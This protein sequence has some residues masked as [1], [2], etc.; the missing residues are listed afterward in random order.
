M[1]SLEQTVQDTLSPSAD[2]RKNAENLLTTASKQP[3]HLVQ[4][5]QLVDNSQQQLPIRQAAAIRFKNIVKVAWDETKDLADRQEITI[6]PTDRQTIKTNLVSLMCTVPPQIRNQVSAAISLIAEVDYPEKWENLLPDLVRQFDSADMNVVNGVLM[7]ADSIFKSFLD[8]QRSDQLYS[9]ILYTLNVIQEPL[10]K[11]FVKMGTE[12]DA[13]PTDAAKLTPRFEALRLI[14][15]IYYSLVYQDLPEYFENNM[16]AWMDGFAKFLQYKN[17][18][19]VD[20]DE[21]D[22][23]GPIDKLQ[24]EIVRI[25]KLFVERDEEPFAEFLQ[26]FTTLVW[27]LLVSSTSPHTKHDQLV[28]MSMKFL[29]VLVGRQYYNSLFTGEG[30]LQQIISQIVI[31]NM[32]VREVDEE[33]FEDNPYDYILTE[34]EGSDNESR[35]RCSRELLGAMCRQFEAQTTGICSEY[36]TQMIAEYDKDKSN[37]IAKDTAIHLMLGISIR[38]ESS[39]GVSEVNGNVNLL[40]FFSVQVL[41]EIQDASHQTRP[42][43]KATAINFVSIFRNQFSREHLVQLMPLLISHLGSM[44]VAVHTLAANTIERI[45]W[46]KEKNGSGVDPYK[47]TRAD[48]QPL[49]EGLF[50]GLFHI[51]DN[52]VLNENEYVMK[53]VMRTLDRCA[54]D[55]LA[56]TAAVFDKLFPALERVCKNPRNPGF[57]HNLFESLALLVKNC[58]SK[59]P[60]QVAA[61]E[62]RV[63]PPFQT[64]L[65]SEILEFTPYVFQILAQL[66]EYKPTGTPL[67]DAYKSLLPAIVHPSSWENSANVPGMSRLL[68]AYIKLSAPELVA[69]NQLTPMLG[70]FQKLNALNATDASAFEILTAITSYVPLEAIS[71]YIN[72]IFALIMTK[73]SGKKSNRYPILSSQYFALFCGLHGGQ[74]FV[75][76]LNS[77]QPGVA[78]NLIGGVWAS[79]VT[80][81]AANKVLAKAQLVGGGRLLSEVPDFLSSNAGKQAWGKVFVG[82]ITLATSSTFSSTVELSTVDEED[83]PLSYDAGFNQL[84]YAKKVPND[85]FQNIPDPLATLGGSLTQTSQTHPGVLPAL[86][87]ESLGSNQELSAAFGNFCESRGVRLS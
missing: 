15:S 18:V 59:D 75:N 20:D 36:I 27:N 41:P 48:L 39:Y 46:T 32:K 13:L 8:V 64:I 42:M 79:K 44:S 25:F 1:A 61:I 78:F 87:Q 56:I 68:A 35:R 70:I 21:E 51:V 23:P 53:C 43:L 55:V 37:W 45:L 28:V 22:E 76:A 9:V 60:S 73:L 34:L 74:A 29:S 47:L 10:L 17:P 11:L 63:F 3:G 24:T 62:S 81:A 14:S 71:Q 49:L 57:N 77:I 31:P 67:S 85:A 6:S 84:R 72:T 86:I 83:T 80:G 12:I 19:L 4:L 30:T 2:V 66:L 50:T 33:N 82:L 52:T 5:L 54:D 40:E 58:C 16:K 26:N 69:E 7:T 65:V 38:K